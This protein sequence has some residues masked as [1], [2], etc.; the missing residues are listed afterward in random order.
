MLALHPDQVRTAKMKDDGPVTRPAEGRRIPDMLRAQPYYMM[1]N[2]DEL[3]A[4]GTLGCPSQASAEK[5]ARFLD[6]A[7]EGV[8]AL[9]RSFVAGELEFPRP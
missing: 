2:F 5:G 9:L 8:A 4:S 3:S 6:A 1:R 7:V